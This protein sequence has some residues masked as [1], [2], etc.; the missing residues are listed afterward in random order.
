MPNHTST[1]LRIYGEKE[2]LEEFVKNNS[3]KEQPFSFEASH[4]TPSET[5]KDRS[6]VG[7]DGKFKMPDWYEWRITNW[8]TKWDCYDH[9]GG[10]EFD[11]DEEAMSFYAEISYYTAWSPATEYFKKVSKAYPS[12]VFHQTYADEGGGF[13]GED[14]IMN[15][16]IESVHDYDWESEK[17][18]EL[19]EKL[20]YYYPEDEEELAN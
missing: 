3:T 7:D 18:I 4:P 6:N 20:G 8:G 10:W 13:V 5:L 15:G 17:G 14:E 11:L 16:V 2:K 12:L 9:H 1:I 19:R